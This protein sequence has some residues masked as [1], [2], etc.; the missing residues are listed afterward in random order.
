ML[1]IRA[2]AL[3]LTV[4]G[5]SPIALS[6]CGEDPSTAAAGL[7]ETSA[8]AAP[9]LSPEVEPEVG[10]GAITAPTLPPDEPGPFR[11]GAFE[12]AWLDE[13]RGREL[14]LTVWYPT[15]STEGETL[16]YLKG[17]ITEGHAL[18]DA[19]PAGPG[20]WPV[21]LFSHGNQAFRE[22]SFFLTEHLASHGYVVIGADHIGNSVY[23][24]ENTAFVQN[25]MDR[26]RDIAAL[27]DALEAW[28]E[29]QEHPLFGLLD[30]DKVGV[31]GHSFGG[32]ATFAAA[33]AEVDMIKMHGTCVERGAGAWDGEWR[34]CEQIISSDLSAAEACHPCDLGDPRIKAAIPMAPAFAEHFTD[35]GVAQIT[36]PV[37]IM[38]GSLDSTWNPD[39]LGARYFDRLDQPDSLLWIL[40]G[41][42]HYSFSD[43]CT[44]EKLKDLSLFECRDD[45]IDPARGHQLMR[46]AATAFFGLHLKGDP[47]YGLAFEAEALAATP[48]V[49]VQTKD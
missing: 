29:D 11:V 42:S 26:P 40:E 1:N 16:P 20:P 17:L 28:N 49:T 47:S 7:G 45:V 36:M 41:A 39:Y 32:Y 31:T 46:G 3:L 30:I 14:P 19:P 23:A 21:V 2:G 43:A 8:D 22:Q 9:E 6:S 13:A 38:G 48:E 10:S 5:I 37:L 15:S 25:T 12:G 27:I 4:L 35:T 34:Y 24:Y 18:A 44:V 33:G